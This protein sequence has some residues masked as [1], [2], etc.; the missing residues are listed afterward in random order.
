MRGEYNLIKSQDG[1]VSTLIF[2]LLEALRLCI[3][4]HFYSRGPF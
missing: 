3:F 2:F 1:W 4:T